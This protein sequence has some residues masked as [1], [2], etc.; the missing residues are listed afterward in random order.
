MNPGIYDITLTEN[1]MCWKVIKQTINVNSEVVQVP[2]FIQIGY[3]VFFTSSHNTQ[4]SYKMP[5]E[6]NKITVPISNGKSKI[7]LE[8]SG[9]YNF[10]LDS[11]HSYESNIISYN[12]ESPQNEIYLNAIKHTLTLLIESESRKETITA[13]V[14]IGGVKLPIESLPY[15][16][17]G[18]E[19]KL[20]LNPGETAVIVP[21]SDVLYF[22][23]PILSV[24]GKTD[25]ENLGAK[26]KAV[27][28][29]VFQGKIKPPL[30]GVL[31]TVETEN[32]DNLMVET[33]EN[34]LYKFPPLDKSKTYKIGAKKDSYV[35]VGP[36]DQGDFL[37]HKLAEIIIEVLDNKTKT[38]L[39]VANNERR[40]DELI[41][42]LFIF[43]ALYFH[44]L[45]ATV[46]EVIYKRTKMV[47]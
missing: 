19:I 25:C 17:N 30:P 42:T 15:T 47:K 44:C 22:T 6:T 45:V 23:P 28:G 35:L 8:K 4:V 27:L 36:N 31:V 16:E 2:P 1:R 5:N 38:P 29:V 24:T 14:S 9:I 13:A 40:M 32:F 10:E 21:H 18:Y 43:R 33:D 41:H 3:N 12:T 39:Q 46:T 20:N 7:C 11:C 37:A 34:G 26:V